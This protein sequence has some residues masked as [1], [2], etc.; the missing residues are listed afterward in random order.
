M[1]PVGHHQ[2][3]LKVSKN[4]WQLQMLNAMKVFQH[5]QA[6]MT[7]VIKYT[8]P[9]M[10]YAFS[11]S[12]IST[13]SFIHRVFSNESS[14]ESSSKRSP[15]RSLFSL[16]WY[17]KLTFTSKECPPFPQSLL[18]RVFSKILFKESP[19]RGLFNHRF[20]KHREEDINFY[21]HSP[22]KFHTKESP[23]KS[24]W[25]FSKVQRVSLESL[26]V[27]CMSFHH[28]GNREYS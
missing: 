22:P 2:M 8:I 26:K 15:S 28:F 23:L 16:V 20:S 14:L 3:Q 27:L 18:Y 12:S 1:D 24:R 6:K 5:L 13:V 10:K 11:L 17:M 9:G 25:I 21:K 19:V 7:L 4:H